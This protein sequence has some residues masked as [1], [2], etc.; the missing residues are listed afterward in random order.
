MASRQ[1]Y[2]RPGQ[3]PEIFG[4]S[5]TTIYRWV[6]AG[7]FQIYKRGQN[8]MIRVADVEKYITGL[9]GSLGGA[10]APRDVS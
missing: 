3:A 8:S 6:Q 7:H 4:I 5:R 1:L 9:G 10:D 2:M